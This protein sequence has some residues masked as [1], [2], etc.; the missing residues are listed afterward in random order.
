MGKKRSKSKNPPVEEPAGPF[1]T[2]FAGLAGLRETLPK[3]D[4]LPVESEQPA[5]TDEATSIVGK[6]VLQRERKGRGGKTVTRVRGLD[7]DALDSWCKR[8]KREL[9]CGGVVEG[10]DVILNGDIADRVAP[11]LLGAGVRSVVHGN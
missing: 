2:A 3:G 5:Q 7:A 1:N 6:A 10:D 11:L 8:L 9:G 4:P